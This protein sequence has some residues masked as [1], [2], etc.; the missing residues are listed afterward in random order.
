MSK[1]LLIETLLV[2]PG[3][4][5]SLL[6]SLSKSGPSYVKESTNG[7]LIV[8]LPATTLDVKNENGRTYST[9]M[10]EQALKNCEE[11][12]KRR[13]LT[14][15][16]DD[17]PETTHVAPG[18]ASHIVTRAWCENG[19]LMN[20]WEILNT[21]K[22]RDLQA[23][24]DANVSFGVSIRGLGSE[25][26]YGNI[27]EDYEYLG[28]D[29]VGNPSAR[30][31]TAPEHVVQESR[32][33]ATR[34]ETIMDPT[35]IRKFLKEQVVL[36]KAEASPAAMYARAAQVEA[37]L[38]QDLVALPAREVADIMHEWD[39]EKSK[40]LENV[41]ALKEGTEDYKAKYEQMQKAIE[42]I[43]KTYRE[44]TRATTTRLKAELAKTL[45][46]ARRQRVTLTKTLETRN[47]RIAQL[48][49]ALRT[50]RQEVTALRA[51]NA[52]LTRLYGLSLENRQQLQTMRDVAIQEAGKARA[53]L[54]DTNTMLNVAVK[55]AAT[56]GV[57]LKKSKTTERAAPKSEAAPK[58]R[59]NT[60]GVPVRASIVEQKGA[61]PKKARSTQ[62]VRGWL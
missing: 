20:E 27:L 17:H 26:G 12:I 55:E 40:V 24:I 50:R 6:E 13:Q 35:S 33:K 31:Y 39:S 15:T 21:S 58:K 61:A 10:F 52:K 22:G 41:Q 56:R 60:D 14:C 54:A 28:T 42:Q 18:N 34:T 3:Q 4:G 49:Q 57:A 62:P 8:K 19:F 9:T 5:S 53:A 46:A 11:A 37:R 16:V 25:D 7:K 45:A 36:M 30:I 47:G 38:G 44:S 32:N 59:L 1:K 51:S 48:N 43:T 2:T 29:C 23:L